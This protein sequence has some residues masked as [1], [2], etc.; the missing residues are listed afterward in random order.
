MR[1]KL[2]ITGIHGIHL[3]CLPRLCLPIGSAENMAKIISRANRADG[4]MM[5]QAASQRAS[6]GGRNQSWSSHH[7]GQWWCMLLL[8]EEQGRI[9]ALVPARR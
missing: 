1:G 7:Q 2:I 9:A 6:A 5:L 4:N 8:L 3:N